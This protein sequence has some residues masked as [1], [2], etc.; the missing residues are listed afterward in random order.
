M[1]IFSWVDPTSSFSIYR[2]L[3][4]KAPADFAQCRHMSWSR[5]KSNPPYQ[6]TNK[7]IKMDSILKSRTLKSNEFITPLWGVTNM[8]MRKA[9]I[10]IYLQKVGED[11]YGRV[12][13]EQLAL[14][15]PGNATGIAPDSEDCA[16]TTIFIRQKVVMEI[17]D[18]S[19]AAGISLRL[20][21]STLTL[22]LVQPNENWNAESSF[23]SFDQP[24]WSQSPPVA[25]FKL[26]DTL[27][28]ITIAIDASKPWGNF[29][30]VKDG[31]K[32]AEHKSLSMHRVHCRKPSQP[33]IEIMLQRG[34][35]DSQSKILL[36]ATRRVI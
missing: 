28:S 16:L 11:Q 9:M 33:M 15:P 29:V 32:A 20:K 24:P 4:A 17:L 35:F 6:L 31:W 8:K 5:S 25:E 18:H 34:L 22:D 7:G 1:S 13:P 27:G 21:P 30:T 3:L 2:G 26:V 14:I 10:G 12:E 19:R 23:F 36:S